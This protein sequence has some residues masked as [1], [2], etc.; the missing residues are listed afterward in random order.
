MDRTRDILGERMDVN[1]E[2]SDFD[3]PAEKTPTMTDSELRSRLREAGAALA[4]ADLDPP[5]RL[6]HLYTIDQALRR[7]QK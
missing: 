5:A 4:L 1:L 3:Q 7:L 2:P 6:R